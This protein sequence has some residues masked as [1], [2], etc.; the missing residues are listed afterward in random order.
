MVRASDAVA[1][2]SWEAGLPSTSAWNG[3]AMVWVLNDQASKISSRLGALMAASRKRSTG[4][5]ALHSCER[6]TIDARPLG[7]C[8]SNGVELRVTNVPE[9]NRLIRFLS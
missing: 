9:A 7:S 8:G 5:C 1:E 6:P 2:V 4:A 3:E